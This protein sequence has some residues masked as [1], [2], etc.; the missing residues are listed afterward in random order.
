MWR[1]LSRIR[2]RFRKYFNRR[3]L[4]IFHETT[5][6]SFEDAFGKSV[7]DWA[8]DI[9]HAHDSVTWHTAARAASYLGARLVFDSHELEAHRNPPMSWRQRRRVE[10]LERTCLPQADKV[11]TVSNLIADYLAREYRIRR[12][13]VIYNSP[14]ARVSTSPENRTN[15]RAEL[16]LCANDFI[17]VYTG[18]ATLNRGLELVVI[19]LERLQGVRDPARRFSGTYHLAIV[20]NQS[21]DAKP[22]LAALA[23]QSRVGDKVHFLPPVPPEYVADYISTA[24]ASIIPV[25]PVTLSY[26]YA[27]P[28]KLFEAILAGNPIIGAD[29]MEMAPFIADNR[30]G[31]TYQADSLDDCVEKMIDLIIRFQE[32]ERSAE[33]Q[34]ELA[35][36]YAWEAQEKTLLAM[37]DDMLNSPARAAS[38]SKGRHP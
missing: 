27:M 10:R 23:R 16:D 17:L 25:M 30:L 22:K 2:G 37:Y 29:L 5:Y 13:T 31:L 11:I 19:A 36:K 9:I 1:V 3:L 20:G 7:R 35:R 34:H 18:N 14:P 8:P 32:F 28:N 21:G 26:E 24:N 15:L 12:P 38:S 33:Q 6:R 4:A